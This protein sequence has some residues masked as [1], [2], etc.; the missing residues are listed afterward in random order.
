MIENDVINRIEKLMNYNHWTVY[1]LAKESDLSYSSLN[2]IFNRRTCPSVPTLEKI[3]TGLNISLSD[4]FDYKKNPL[5]SKEL[6][7]SEQ[8]IINIYRS[9]SVQDKI[10]LEAYLDGLGKKK[11]RN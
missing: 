4:F 7:D 11:R 2:N 1:K 9:L 3:C 6:S 10:I 8:N 5:K